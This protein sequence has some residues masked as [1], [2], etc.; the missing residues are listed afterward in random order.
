MTPRPSPKPFDLATPVGRTRA[1]A[2]YLWRD[3]AYLRLGF[4]N[5]HWIS[6]ELVRANQPWPHQ[7]AVWK[8]AGIRTVINLR[9]GFDASFYALERQACA[10]LGM[11]MVDF[12]VTSREVPSREQILGA[13]ELFQRV[14]YPALM[15]CKSGADRAGVMSVLYMHFR[16]GLPIRKALQQLSLRYLHVRQGK[17]GVL[18]YFF[19]RYLEDAE[20]RGVSFVDWVESPDFDPKGMKATFRAQMLGSLITERL[21][22]RE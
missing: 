4:S 14:A 1:Y 22:R 13:R 17:T 20:P 16:K 19:E 9:G 5:A 21:L 18:D 2:D 6:E 7:L 12:T 15:H 10:D 11:E 3:H 8:K